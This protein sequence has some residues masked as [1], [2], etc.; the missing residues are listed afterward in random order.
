MATPRIFVS[1]SHIDDEWCRCF[2]QELRIAGFDV[3]YDA[4][5]LR[6]GDFWIE[7]IEKELP[8]REIFMVILTPDAWQ[9][10]WVRKETELAISTK[11]KIVR[12]QHEATETPGFLSL[13]PMVID[14][15]G[16]D[17]TT[18]AHQMIT[19]LVR[20]YGPVE[21]AVQKEVPPGTPPSPTKRRVPVIP[22]AVAFLLIAST[23]L[24]AI[25]RF[26]MTKPPAPVVYTVYGLLSDGTAVAVNAGDDAAAQSC[27]RLCVAAGYTGGL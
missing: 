4:R 15:V 5:N 24:F 2:V 18:A 27:T 26:T 17:C 22:L 12:V 7:N 6:G 23:L 14:V 3:W 16:Q 10:S 11:R 21:P 8:S 25:S 9:S 20:L 19:E 1:H 13:E